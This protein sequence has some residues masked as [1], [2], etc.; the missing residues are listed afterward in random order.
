MKI[1]FLGKDDRY[2]IV[3]D[4]LK[5]K[6]DIYTIGYDDIKGVKKGKYSNINDYD[7]IVLPMSGIKNGRASNV[8]LQPNILDEYKGVIYTG[9]TE[10][11]KGNVESFLD[12]K[13][14]RDENTLITVDGIMHKIRN[15]CKDSICILGYGNIGSKLYERLNDK[16]KVVVGVEDKDEGILENSFLTS[17]KEDLKEALINSN[18]IINTVPKH[19][20]DEDILKQMEGAFLDIASTPYA[21]DQVKV[22]DYPFE[23]QLYSSIPSKYAPDRAG[24]VLLKKFEGVKF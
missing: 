1:L 15:I 18:L 11:L 4:T 22:F 12:D 5:V 3:I 23:Y 24:R 7:I 13:E 10:G 14:I 9:R 19:I 2:K 20:I 8:V 16:Y 6:N 17:N 21:V